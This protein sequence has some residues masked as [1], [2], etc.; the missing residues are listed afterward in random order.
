MHR[1]PVGYWNLRHH[2]G[3]D[4]YLA[5]SAAVDHRCMPCVYIFCHFSFALIIIHSW[6]YILLHAYLPKVNLHELIGNGFD[7][8][9]KVHGSWAERQ[10][11]SNLG[12]RLW[13]PSVGDAA[14]SH[15]R[16]A[17]SRCSCSATPWQGKSLHLPEASY[18]SWPEDGVPGGERP[19]GTVGEASG[20]LW[21]AEGSTSPTSQA[22][23]GTTPLPRLQESWGI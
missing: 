15:D 6:R 4:G 8:Q 21:Q 13:V 14:D 18:S 11:L 23:L 19:S 10:E 12:T 17:C 20:M 16:Q 1:G 22:W 3:P 7:Q 9:D 2:H 5:M